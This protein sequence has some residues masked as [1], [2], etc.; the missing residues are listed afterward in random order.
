MSKYGNKRTTVGTITFDSIAEARRYQELQVMERA[1]LITRLVCQPEWELIP[2]YKRKDGT[3]VRATKYRA[4]FSYTDTESGE[5]IVED[6][7]GKATEV[8]KIKR[9]LFEYMFTDMTFKEVA[10]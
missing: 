1:G 2:A 10:A 5:Y 7:K 9:K 4:D 8:Y 6:V 3:K